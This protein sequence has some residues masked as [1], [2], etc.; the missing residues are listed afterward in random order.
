[1]KK[2]IKKGLSLVLAAILLLSLVPAASAASS[3]F[4]DITD[5]VTAQNVEVLRMMGVIDGMTATT[6]Q[7]GGTLTRAQ[8]CKM[9]GS[10]LAGETVIRVNPAQAIIEIRLADHNVRD[11][12]TADQRGQLLR[13]HRHM[14]HEAIHPVLRPGLLHISDSVLAVQVL[15]HH[16]VAFFV[17]R[18]LNAAHDLEQVRIDKRRVKGE[19]GEE[20][21]LVGCAGR[22]VA[23]A[24]IGLVPQ[25]LGGLPDLLL[26]F[27][28]Y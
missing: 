27:L 20:G 12:F 16:G 19:V 3:Q 7:P 1:M 6:F 11:V 25:R 15:H 17:Q 18:M 14:Q 2:L 24:G 13:H 5:P 28:G 4:T 10:E 21:H 23:G 8:F 22:K 26:R 9:A